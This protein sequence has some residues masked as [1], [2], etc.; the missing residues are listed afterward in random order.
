MERHNSGVN[1][2]FMDGSARHIGNLEDL[3][4]LRW[5][6]KF[7]VNYEPNTGQP[8]DNTILSLE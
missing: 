6:N 4:T 1:L 3:Y 2:T 7:D 5:S 8:F